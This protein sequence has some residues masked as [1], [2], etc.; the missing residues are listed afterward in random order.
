MCSAAEEEAAY[1]AAEE[2]EEEALREAERRRRRARADAAA[3]R[4]R[5]RDVEAKR[6][7]AR[8]RAVGKLPLVMERI[9]RETAALVVVKIGTSSVA[10]ALLEE[11]DVRPPEGWTRVPSDTKCVWAAKVGDAHVAFAAASGA[12]EGDAALATAIKTK[13]RLAEDTSTSV[14]FCSI[15]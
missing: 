14:I 2:A 3:E 11:L 1:R 9:A 5:Q 8:S 15:S 13:L 7:L 6:L 4:A 12:E 10:D